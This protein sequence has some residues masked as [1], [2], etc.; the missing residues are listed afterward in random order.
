MWTSPAPFKHG[1]KLGAGKVSMGLPKLQ[2]IAG[3]FIVRVA[4]ED[5]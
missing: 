2:D 1:P 4:A 3:T 5:F